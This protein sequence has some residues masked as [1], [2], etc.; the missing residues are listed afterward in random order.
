M[1]CCGIGSGNVNGISCWNVESATNVELT[2]LGL[3][4]LLFLAGAIYMMYMSGLKGCEYCST[5]E[6]WGLLLPNVFMSSAFFIMIFK[7][8]VCPSPEI[9][10]T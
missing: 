1:S 9:N 5:C 4:N 8:K 3:G 7:D 10:K 2:C 6:F